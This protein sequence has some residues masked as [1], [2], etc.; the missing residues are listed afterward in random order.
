SLTK[1][2]GDPEIEGGVETSL[3][4]GFRNQHRP[5]EAI[6]FG[7]EAVN[8]YQ[9]IRRNI[10]GLDKDLQAGFAQSKSAT[11]RTLAELLVQADR[12]GEAEQILDLL[13]E[14]EL[15]DIVRGA[16]PDAGAKIE[17][18]KLTAAQ[19][20][21]QGDLATPEKMAV[22]LTDLCM[23][24]AELQAKAARTADEETRL[25]QLNASIEQGIRAILAF[26]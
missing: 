21:A 22:A 19:Q 1:A 17:P 15:K 5:E 10:S 7:M 16:A 6:F 9:Q 20:K 4:V 25:K 3:M 24:N 14:Q 18:M 13:K 26:F 8:S 12:L 2:A 23:E 11:Y